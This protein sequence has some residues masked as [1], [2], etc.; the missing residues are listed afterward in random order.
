MGGA[1]LRTWKTWRD[2]WRHL[3]FL[4]MYSPRWLFLFPGLTLMLGGLGAWM[5][6]LLPTERPLGSL[7]LGVDTLAYAGAAVLLG[8]QL[9]FF[10]IAAKVFA[11]TEGL[12]PEDESFQRWFRFVTLETGLIL[13]VVLLVLA[14]S[15][16]CDFRR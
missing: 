10:G 5:V 6:W 11:I 3:R 16:D 13:G 7:N 14:G 4:L 15:G 8:F 12:L 9:I 1:G 2:G